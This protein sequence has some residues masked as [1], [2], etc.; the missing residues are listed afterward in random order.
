MLGISRLLRGH[1]TADS[2]QPIPVRLPSG[3]PITAVDD[4]VERAAFIPSMLSPES[5]KFLYA[6]CYLQQIAG[7]VVEIGS[8]QGYSTSFLARAVKDS[9]NGSFFAI[10][11]FRGNVGKEDRYRVGA[12]D[13]SDL[14]ANFERNMRQ[15]GVWD[16]VH[17]LDMPDDDAAERLHGRTVRFLFIDGDHSRSGVEKDIRLF[18]PLLHPGAIVVFDDFAPRFPGLLEAV[19]DLLAK[20][21]VRRA[22]SYRNTLVVGM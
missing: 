15:L 18:F 6:L 16:A 5:G 11:H 8:W 13:L 22:F 3:R 14:R 20:S 17:L 9:G 1:A 12:A 7:D 21:P 2:L 10:D 4:L 19:D